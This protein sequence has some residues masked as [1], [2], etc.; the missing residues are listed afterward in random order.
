MT[1]TTRN[2][3][4]TAWIV[5]L[6]LM[7]TAITLLVVLVFVKYAAAREHA[8]SNDTRARL[9]VCQTAFAMYGED[10]GKLPT[11]QIF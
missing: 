3:P 10:L 8:C 5:A 9:A 2:G 1:A 7:V 4:G 6:A 11:R